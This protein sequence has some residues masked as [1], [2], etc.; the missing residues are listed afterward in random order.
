MALRS[1]GG[2]SHRLLP[3]RVASV[4]LIAISHRATE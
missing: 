2:S 1:L 4:E 3:Q